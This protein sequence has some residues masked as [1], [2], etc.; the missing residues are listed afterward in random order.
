MPP[1]APALQTRGLCKDFRGFRAVDGVDLTRRRRRGARAGRAER[2][3]QDDAVQPAHRLPAR[4][5]PGGSRSAGRDVTGAAAGA[6]RPAR[7]GPLVPDHQP[8]PAS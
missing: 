7:R 2:R 6:D 4:R 3:G 1:A 5:P 8:V